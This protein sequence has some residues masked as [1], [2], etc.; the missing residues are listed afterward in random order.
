MPPVS[1]FAK[2]SR[3]IL[4]EWARIKAERGQTEEV[5]RIVAAIEEI[6]QDVL[7]GKHQSPVYSESARAYLRRGMDELRAQAKIS[8][9]E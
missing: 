6:V 2:N 1:R 5:V 4:Q 7:D 3:P 8:L 9:G